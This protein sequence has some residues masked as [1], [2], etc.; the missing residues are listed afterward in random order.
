MTAAEIYDSVTNGGTSDFSDIAAILDRNKPWCL[1]GGLAVNCYV[2]PVYTV[3]VDLVVATEKTSVIG[4]EL[5]K[6]GLRV[7]Q[8][9]QPEFPSPCD[10]VVPLSL[11]ER[12]GVRAIGRSKLN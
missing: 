5:A 11:R 6:A 12:A 9:E 1:I 3:D 7:Q 10:F 4:N 8:F 2:E